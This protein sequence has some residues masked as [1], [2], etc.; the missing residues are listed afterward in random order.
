MDGSVNKAI[1]GGITG[2]ILTVLAHYGLQPHADTVTAL[3]VVVYAIVG[4][5]IG[6]L[7]VFFAPSNKPKL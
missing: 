7:S 2:A 3:G 6:H 4:Y 5:I 1:A